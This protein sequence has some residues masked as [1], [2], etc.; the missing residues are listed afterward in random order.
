MACFVLSRSRLQN[1]LLCWPRRLRAMR[2]GFNFRSPIAGSK[3]SDNKLT[4]SRT[5]SGQFSKSADSVLEGKAQNSSQCGHGNYFSTLGV[6]PA[7]GRLFRPGEGER[8][9]GSLL[10]VL[11]YS[12]WQ[13]RFGVTRLAEEIRR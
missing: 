13:K 1:K 5:S 8:S 12:F 11:G 3:I 7:V 9:G 6:Q 2:P 4:F 10:V